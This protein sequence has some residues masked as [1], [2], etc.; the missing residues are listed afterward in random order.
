[1]KLI[2]NAD[3]FGYSKA[4]NLG[5]LEAYKNGVVSSTT[6]MT[7]MPGADHAFEIAKE[8]P[9]LGVGIH[10]VLSC[11]G[12]VSNDVQSLIGDDGK[13]HHIDNVSKYAKPEDVR[14][15]FEAQME[16]FLAS[17][18]TPTHI[19]SHHHVHGNEMVLQIVL[20]LANKY[21]LPVRIFDKTSIQG[22]YSNIKA[23][24]YF[25]GKFYGEDL[26]EKRF[27]EEVSVE[28]KEIMELM[29]H[30]AYLDKEILWGSSYNTQRVV[31]LDIL[32]G[33]ELKEKLNR[34]GI[35]LVNYKA[36]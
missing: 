20:E 9:G 4:V 15:E 31:E 26:T 21:D 10:L 25:T 35:K 18:L 6:L 3:D 8:N 12:P 34:R 30:P 32:T 1:M 27:L 19:D 2:V 23:V 28:D 17:G 22:K 14:K 33:P 16:K 29:C 5:I 13:F 36:L 7:N 11:G 24:D